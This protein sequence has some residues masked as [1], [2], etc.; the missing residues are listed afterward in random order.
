M[1]VEVEIKVAITLNASKMIWVKLEKCSDKIKV[2]E[3]KNKLG[4]LEVYIDNDR[5]K[6]ERE[7]Q[8]KVI[9]YAKQ[10]KAAGNDMTIRFWKLRI[11]D[12]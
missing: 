12:K 11:G 8:K 5:M 4:N 3:N 1:G 6:K 2:M 9:S 7:V 10:E